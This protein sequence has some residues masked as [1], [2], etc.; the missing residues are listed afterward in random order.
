MHYSTA[1]S[2]LFIFL[3]SAAAITARAQEATSTPSTT[4]PAVG[5]FAFRETLRYTR[6]GTDP[7]NS[8]RHGEMLISQSTLQYGVLSNLS[9]TLDVPTVLLD[10]RTTR[11][12]RRDTDSGVADLSLYAKWRVWQLDSSPLNTT[13]L[14]LLGGAELP[15]GDGT[16]FSES[17]D[18][19]AGIVLMTIQDRWGFTQALRYKFNTAGEGHGTRLAGDTAA[20]AL[21]HDTAVLYRVDPARY[22]ATTEAASYFMLEL[23][24]L[25]ETSGDY[26]LHVSPGF[27]YEAR[28]FAAEISV[29]LPAYE[30]VRHRA[31]TSIGVSVGIRFLF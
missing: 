28:T 22:S 5:H 24:G 20:D 25:Y 9:V 30:H 21:R 15:S 18:P 31:A 17:V 26:E 12:G 8:D 3:V 16:Y 6:Q 23:N 14:S 1:Q 10:S 13:R 29:L 4:Q 11:G 19:F 7:M 2:L 27:L